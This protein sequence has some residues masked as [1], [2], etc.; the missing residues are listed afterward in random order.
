M[1]ME[2]C[3]IARLKENDAYD[4]PNKCTECGSAHL[5]RDYARGELYC[6]SCGLVLMEDYIL[7]EQEWRGYTPEQREERSRTGQ[8]GTYTLHDRG[9]STNILNISRDSQGK[10]L[11]RDAKRRFY[12]MRK[13][14]N[15]LKFSS[16]KEK[17]LAI[18]LA[19]VDRFVSYLGL[20]KGYKETASLLYRKAAARNL[21]RGRSVQTVA[22]A[23]IYT[24]C[25]MNSIPRTLDEVAK[26]C[27]LTSK[28][29]KKKI[30]KAYRAIVKALKLKVVPVRPEQYLSRFSAELELGSKTYAE[31]LKIIKR[32]QEVENLRSTI[33]AGIV[34]AALYIAAQKTGE[35]VTQKKIADMVG[36]SEPTLR[37]RYHDLTK[38]LKAPSI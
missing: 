27:S 19:H 9:L 21:I 23:V 17:R 6:E 16:Q 32:A 7:E 3:E 20:S 30:G 29:D 36:V 34:A 13:L 31:A 10:F 26:A 12:R 22:A 4:E 14:H 38:I 24:I 11:S 28:P 37:Y 15:R 33:P 25:R 5:V 8:P 35:K 2:K 1:V 18:G